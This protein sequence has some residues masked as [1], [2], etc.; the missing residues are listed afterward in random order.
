MEK[1]L[2]ST[3]SSLKLEMNKSEIDKITQDFFS[4]FTK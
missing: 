2:P 1:I 4:I 3:V